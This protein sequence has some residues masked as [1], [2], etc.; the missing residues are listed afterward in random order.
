MSKTSEEL[1][2]T[3]LSGYLASGRLTK[4]NAEGVAK[5]LKE[6]TEAIEK[7]KAKDQSDN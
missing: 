6:W 4:V 3:L 7:V 2:A 5:L 1:A